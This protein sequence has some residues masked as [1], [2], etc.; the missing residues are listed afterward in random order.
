M[1]DRL[2]KEESGLALPLAIG[3]MVIVGVMGAG[4]LV[5]VNRDLEAVVE[6]NQG[7][8]AFNIADSGIAAASEHLRYDKITSHYD[9]DDPASPLYAAD[10][11]TTDPDEE[12]KPR[13]PAGEN[14]SPEAGVTKTFANGEFTVTI[15]HLASPTDSKCKAP[16]TP[17]NNTNYF[18]V[19]S[20]GEYGDAK[21]KIE[22]IYETYDIGVPK[23]FVA[24]QN[25]TIS[26]NV[27]TG[28]VSLFSMEDIT[29]NNNSSITGEDLVYG[30]WDTYP[31]GTDNPYNDT[32]RGQTAAGLGTQGNID[33]DNEVSGRDYDGSAD[34]KGE[35]LVY[36]PSD[37]QSATEITF[38]FDPKPD[39]LDADTL[40]NI[41]QSQDSIDNAHYQPV[42]TSGSYSI[43]DWPTSNT[44][45]TIV[46]VDFVAGS[47]GSRTA[48]WSVDG[49]FNLSAPYPNQCEGPIRNGI[50]VVR[51]GNFKAAQNKSLFSG[52]IVVR[53]G[54]VEGDYTNT[55]GNP[56]LEGFANASGEIKLSGNVEPYSTGNLADLPGFYGVRQWSWRECYSEDCS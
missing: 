13:I 52:P 8:K 41:A 28:N 21:R 54:V 14:W 18:R 3:V 50:L 10:C 34:G 42:S 55:G 17:S 5:F 6:V 7:Q 33:N 9:V 37:P 51:G 40:C 24:R 39:A 38:P 20:T 47:G 11:D 29:V 12:G 44:T 4:L 46:C 31:N 25:L 36:P 48:T 16:E 53:G 19:V 49:D 2:I 1:L 56:C 27:E 32:P 30:N 45:N 22:S 43:V 15:R 35:Q 26:G 23:A